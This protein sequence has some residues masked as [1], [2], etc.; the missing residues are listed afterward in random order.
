MV[1][2]HKNKTN[3]PISSNS[4][5]SATANKAIHCLK[6]GDLIKQ[7]ETSYNFDKIWSG[8]PE[9]RFGKLFLIRDANNFDKSPN[10]I[11]FAGKFTH[12]FIRT[13][14]K[15]I[16]MPSMKAHLHNY[17]YR[18]CN[19]VI[20]LEKRMKY[21]ISD[22]CFNKRWSHM[23]TR[24]ELQCII[25]FVTPELTVPSPHIRLWVPEN[26]SNVYEIQGPSTDG[27]FIV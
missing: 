26:L 10:S 5:P 3:H 20:S 12:K 2:L 21:V 15:E 18:F 16:L 1:V 4:H 23:W 6:W 9:G 8:A 27:Q 19:F 22:I 17:H 14:L 25:L 11:I 24:H 13:T 7:T